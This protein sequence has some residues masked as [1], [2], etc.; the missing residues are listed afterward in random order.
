MVIVISRSSN[1]NACVECC[2]ECV[3]LMCQVNQLDRV[4]VTV[5]IYNYSKTTLPTLPPVWSDSPEAK[6]NIFIA[7]SKAAH[8]M[9]GLEYNPQDADDTIA[10]QATPAASE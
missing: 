7:V 5:H 10:A 3:L 6:F 2:S 9:R 8:R 4:P 1:R